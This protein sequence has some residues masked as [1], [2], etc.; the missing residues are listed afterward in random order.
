MMMARCNRRLLVIPFPTVALLAANAASTHFF[1]SCAYC[2]YPSR[3]CHLHTTV[4]SLR[5]QHGAATSHFRLER[6]QNYSASAW[7]TQKK[8]SLRRRAA[9]GRLHVGND[10]CEIISSVRDSLWYDL[11]E[12][13]LCS[14]LRGASYSCSSHDTHTPTLVLILAVSGGC[15]SIAL[16]HSALALTR[17]DNM[18]TTNDGNSS[19]RS[20][21]VTTTWVNNQ[22]LW[23]HLGIDESNPKQLTPR[24]IPCELHVA[25]FNHEQRGESSDGDETFVKT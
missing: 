23:L 18:Y 3:S 25:H 7:G 17:G 15:D 8:I 13:H 12:P 14:R 19:D 20:V 16:F 4:F 6:S 24:R 21:D 22:P 9:T 1:I 10:E 5:R 2:F 11:V